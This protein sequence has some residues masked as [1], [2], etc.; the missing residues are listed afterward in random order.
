MGVPQDYQQW[1]NRQLLDLVKTKG[2][3]LG[4]VFL[5][6]MYDED[7]KKKLCPEWIWTR[8]LTWEGSLSNML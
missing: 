8:N 2:A 7:K 4:L 3:M 6:T 1:T 5:P